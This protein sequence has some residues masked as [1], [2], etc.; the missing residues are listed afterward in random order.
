MPG[1]GLLQTNPL[2]LFVSLTAIQVQKNPSQTP[3]NSRDIEDEK[4]LKSDWP[5]HI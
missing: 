5:E 3:I 1:E 4:I 2:C